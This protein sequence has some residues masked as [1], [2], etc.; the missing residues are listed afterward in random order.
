VVET[1]VNPADWVVVRGQVRVRPGDVVAP[2]TADGKPVP[3]AELP[4]AAPPS[5][6]KQP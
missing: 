2:Q 5:P 4:A 3:L 6:G 1:G